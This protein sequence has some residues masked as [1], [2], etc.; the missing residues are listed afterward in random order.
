MEGANGT[1]VVVVFRKW[2]RASD[3]LGDAV[4]ALFPELESAPGMVASFER[5]GQHG[6]AL[7]EGV[8]AR[9]L[10]ATPGEYASVK[11]ELE[12]APY[13]YQLVMR[14]RRAKR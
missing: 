1:P 2:R 14:V 7:Y 13:Y 5:I 10:P 12:S 8:I 9:T 11:K 3:M 4:I 6:T